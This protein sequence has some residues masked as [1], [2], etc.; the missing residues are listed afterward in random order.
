MAESVEPQTP[1]EEA[2]LR[3]LEIKHRRRHRWIALFWSVAVSGHTT[4]ILHTIWDSWPLHERDL[5]P[6]ALLVVNAVG[7]LGLMAW[8]LRGLRQGEATD[9]Q[10]TLQHAR[11]Q[12]QNRAWHE[13][14]AARQGQRQAGEAR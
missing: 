6:L 7:G 8:G 9:R 12:A 14:R 4:I 5:G 11:W 13:R 1:E 10:W 2:A 3:A